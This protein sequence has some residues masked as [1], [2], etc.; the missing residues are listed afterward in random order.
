MPPPSILA[1][2][3]TPSR[4]ERPLKGRYLGALALILT[5]FLI[6]GYAYQ[7]APGSVEQI[8][9]KQARRALVKERKATHACHDARYRARIYAD[10]AERSSSRPYIQ[11]ATRTWSRRLNTC[12]RKLARDRTHWRA[13]PV[14]KAKQIARWLLR[15]R[16]WSAQYGCLDCLIMSESHWNVHADNPTSDAFGI[17]QALPGSKMGP[18]WQDDPEVQLRWLLYSY[19][20]PGHRYAD[21]CAAWQF[22]R[23]NGW[24]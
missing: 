1:L 16:G 2:A 12:E 8:S 4:K 11:W 3:G 17:P 18:G 7:S 10:H 21:P 23:A 19:M 20:G 15:Q 24:Y 6:T 14:A 13:D 5:L 22:R 9:L